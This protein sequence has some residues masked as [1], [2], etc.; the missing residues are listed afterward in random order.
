MNKIS[1]SAMAFMA[2]ALFGSCS[3][4]GTDGSNEVTDTPRDTSFYVE[5]V[6]PQGEL[7]SSV[8]FPSIQIQFSEPVV[9]LKK[10][11]EPSS[12]SDVVTISPSVNGVFRWYGTSLLSFDCSDALIP[13]KEYTITIN[14]NARSI[15]GTP[16]SGDLVYTFRTEELALRSIEPGYTARKEKKIYLNSQDILPEYAKDI[17]VSFGNKVNGK[18]VSK[19]ILVSDEK[20]KKDYPFTFEQ[21]DDKTLL[22]HVKDSFPRDTELKVVL[23]EGAIPDEDCIATSKE[24]ARTFHTLRPFKHEHTAG[25]ST[26]TISFNHRIKEGQEKSIYRALHFSSTMEIGEESVEIYGNTIFIKDIPVTYGDEYSV[27]LEPSTVCDIYD[28]ICKEEVSYSVTVPDAD[29]YASYKD[30]SFVILESQFE[31][32]RAFEFQN[33]LEDSTYTLTAIS[34]VTDSYKAGKKKTFA[35][36]ATEENKNR[37]VIQAVPLSD[38]LEKTGGSYRGAVK[39]ESNAFYLPYYEAKKREAFTTSSYIQVTD[40]GVTVRTAWNKTDVMVSHMSD[41]SAVKNASVTIRQVSRNNNESHDDI[42][43]KMLLSKGRELCSGKTSDDGLAVLYFNDEDSYSTSKYIEVKTEDDRVVIPLSTW[44]TFYYGTDISNG[45]VIVP[46]SSQTRGE[47]QIFSDR[48]LYRP[49]ETAEVKV[50]DRIRTPGGVYQTYTG[51]YEIN[52]VD[53]TW[54]SKRKV[55]GSSSGN[56]GAQ[57]TASAQWKL[58]EDLVPGSYYVEYRRTDGSNYKSVT[59]LMVQFFERV[60]FQANAEVTPVVYIRGDAITATVNASY[61]GGG[62][63]AGGSVHADWTRSISS[64]APAGEKFEGFTFGP[65]GYDWYW[66][67]DADEE[68]SFYAQEDAS[69]S[70]DGSARLS[71]QTGSGQKAGSP[72]YYSLEAQV[73]DAGNQMIA[74]RTGT[75]V[76][77]AKFYIGLSGIQNIKGF[78]KKGQELEFEYLFATPEGSVPSLTEF[79]F[80]KKVEWELRRKEWEE[81]PYTDDYGYEQ[82]RW[83]EKTVVEQ[84]GSF[85][86][87]NAEK[88]EKL[89]L[90]PKEGGRY[91]LVMQTEDS[92]GNVVKTE[93]SFY[94]TSSD[95]YWWRNSEDAHEITLEADKGEYEAGETATVLLN[96]TLN[97]G[98]Y[99]VTVEREGILSEEVLELTQPTATITVPIKENYVPQVYVN[100]TTFAQRS[101]EA[102]ADYDSSD[103]GKPKSVYGSV[104]LAVSRKSKIFD[105]SVEQDKKTYRPGSDANI[106][107]TATKD[108]KPVANAELTLMVVDRGVLDLI[109]YH[110]ENPVEHFYNSGLFGSGGI[111]VDSF[112]MLVD[113]VTYGTYTLPAKE[114]ILYAFNRMYKTMAT[115]SAADDSVMMMDMAMGSNMVYRE[116]AAVEESLEAEADSG[117]G[118]LQVRKDFRATAVFLPSLTTDS[119]G[120][121]TASFKLPDSLTEYV[122]TV[123]GVKEQTYAY[124]EEA[125]VVANPISVRDV[126]TRILRPGDE[127]EAGVVITNIGDSDENVTINFAVYSGLEKTDYKPEEG[128]LIRLEGKAFVAGESKKAVTVK[129][130]ETQTI[131]FRTK[132]ESQGWITLA[133]T[134]S[135]NEVNEVIYKPLEIEKP[136]VYETVT[137]VGQIDQEESSAEERIVF[138][139][140]TDNGKGSFYIQLDSSRLG[141]LSSAVNYVFHYPYGCLEQRSSA[142]LPLVAFGDYI[143]VFNLN[144]E[145]ADADAVVT[146][147]LKEWA[148]VQRKDGGF[149]YWPD[150]DESSLAVSLRIAEVISIAKE[151]GIKIPLGL[152]TDKLASYIQ[153]E[154][155]DLKEEKYAWRYPEAYA[156]YVLTRL[157]KKVSAS[158]IEAVVSSDTGASEYAFAGLAALS[159][160]NRKLAD[161]AALKIKNMMSLTVRGASFQQN[162]PWYGWYF[163]NGNSE[164]YALA[165]HLFTKLNAEDIYNGHLVYEILQLQK[166]GN[167]WWQSTATTSRVLIALEAYIKTNNLEKTNLT[168]EVLLGGAS[169]LSGKF[170]GV[171]AQPVDRTMDFAL[172]NEKGVSF[173]SEIPLEVTKNGKGQ[174]FYTASLTYA[175]PAQEQKARDEGL[176]VYVEITD[177]RTGEKVEAGKLKSG[178]IY[179]EKVYVTTTK[180]RTFVALRAPVPAGAQILNGAFVT[181]ATVPALEKNTADRNSYWWRSSMSHQDVYDAEIRC[182][183]NYMGIGNQSFEFLFRAERSGTYQTP[184]TLAECMYEPE[185]FGRSDGAVWTIE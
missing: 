99:L 168:A 37:R 147:E 160:G 138:P 44:R 104:S 29:S 183:W 73:I 101:K 115:A 24:Q 178:V 169:V 103:E 91:L 149:P 106:T 49:G 157:G 22:L 69:L 105:I 107:L 140:G 53:N 93:R 50:I 67:N 86:V 35:L 143:S 62:S 64:F 142:V 10:L 148:K 145:V 95:S 163:Y 36:E 12:T 109:G 54:N 60:R 89:L 19:Y 46:V 102:P 181:T 80:A 92:K 30:G 27:R 66:R 52:F 5:S 79:S 125:L 153:N 51:P 121:V 47:T 156:Y 176:C 177:A 55:Y 82:T 41:G 38:F 21:I 68:E 114:R 18:V 84:K 94:V 40:L 164:R 45:D 151:H 182:F 152:N 88:I 165:L 184:A 158:D 112:N 48:M 117:S 74:A 130:G 108:G 144:S 90:T 135:S 8:S 170:V 132:A 146:K 4:M 137:T 11:G 175:L 123:V 127:G 129:S 111:N 100:V 26:L 118:S 122:V 180:E 96:S 128:D 25:T 13:Q 65:L 3:T 113:P 81:V 134:V 1:C 31:P 110:V 154:I 56:T 15:T 57:G 9:A 159:M 61:L 185:V 20:S 172:L 63:L 98:R 133:F 23:K 70:A 97:R 116:E 78:A 39:F 87:K 33:V 119:N 179:R 166:A 58:P 42:N 174:L 34:G 83:E 14:K 43:E 77:P 136:Y 72:Y 171:G 124:A 28:Q 161:T 16:V 150:G 120:K 139:S 85:A 59:S 7:S 141:S 17:A 173:D 155:K 162:S 75:I 131:M 2:A 76:H 6:F 32:N 126:E 167:G 71:C